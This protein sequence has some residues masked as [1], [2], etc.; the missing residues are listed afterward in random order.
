MTEESGVNQKHTVH[1]SGTVQGVGFRYAVLRVSNGFEV[2]GYVRNLPDGRVEVVAEGPTD[3]IR[4][5]IEAIQ[6]EM[7]SYI[8]NVAETV[9]E[10]DACF[11]GF[12]IRF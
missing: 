6:V 10:A 7:G 5:F 8:A 2:S 9:A 3:E 12:D 1:F 4:C 11:R